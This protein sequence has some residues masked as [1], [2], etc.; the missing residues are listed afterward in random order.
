M[1][2]WQKEDRVI[3]LAFLSSSQTLVGLIMWDLYLRVKS[4]TLVI[5]QTC[6]YSR[7]VQKTPRVTHTQKHPPPRCV[8][9]PLVQRQSFSWVAK[10]NEVVTLDWGR[11]S[12]VFL[13]RPFMLGTINMVTLSAC[14]LGE[15]QE[16]ILL[17]PCLQ[18]LLTHHSLSEN[19][20]S[21]W[22]QNTRT[23]GAALIGSPI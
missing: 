12:V 20:C 5:S 3:G 8:S 18:L 9:L 11:K 6:H 1:Q 2:E 21:R 23:Y 15:K 4:S 13:C 17:S 14:F 10:D 22:I 19:T 7:D 16:H